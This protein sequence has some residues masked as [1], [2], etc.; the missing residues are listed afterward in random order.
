[1]LNRAA[2][3]PGGAQGV[4]RHTHA[5]GEGSPIYTESLAESAE[6]ATPWC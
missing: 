2:H 6:A 5:G 3:G 4:S 1:M